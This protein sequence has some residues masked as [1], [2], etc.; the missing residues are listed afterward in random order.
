MSCGNPNM[1]DSCPVEWL[2]AADRADE[3]DR[4][5]YAA[6]WANAEEPASSSGEGEKEYGRAKKTTHFRRN[7][8]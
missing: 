1:D 4:A 3:A 6:S 8:L 5:L 2:E 7:A